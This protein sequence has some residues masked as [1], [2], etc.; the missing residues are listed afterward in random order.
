MAYST[1][2]GPRRNRLP[3]LAGVIALLLGNEASAQQARGQPVTADEMARILGPEEM[4]RREE[5]NRSTQTD[6]Q[7]RAELAATQRRQAQELRE[8]ERYCATIKTRIQREGYRAV[9]ADIGGM[10]MSDCGL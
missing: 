10:Q 3:I 9:E 2:E 4:R 7:L 8:G 5:Y 1:H 6:P